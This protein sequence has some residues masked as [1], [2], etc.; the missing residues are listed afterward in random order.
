MG[1]GIILGLLPVA[2]LALLGRAGFYFGNAVYPVLN[3]VYRGLLFH[4]FGNALIGK[5]VY[6]REELLPNP[7]VAS[8]LFGSVGMSLIAAVRSLRTGRRLPIGIP[9][10]V[11]F[12]LLLA[13]GSLAPTPLWYQYFY[14]PV[15][16][17]ILALVLSASALA[18]VEWRQAVPGAVFGLVVV[19]SAAAGWSRMAILSRLADP[20]SWIPVEVHHAGKVLAGRVKEG[21]VLTL[22]PIVPLEGGLQ[23]FPEFA[24]GP[25]TWRVA[26]LLSPE[27]RDR[28]GVVSYQ[29]FS[30]YLESDPPSAIA[31]GF[32]AKNE[33]FVRG[34]EGGVEDPLR[35][36][37][38]ENGYTPI[39][40][41][42]D[43]TPEP[44]ILWVRD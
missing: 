37:A 36:Y 8:L 19:V 20:S 27:R 10:A 41:D 9:L 17:L 4:W 42:A 6:L 29:D 7:A 5:M 39:S 32:E 28:Y 3:S 30:A 15:P 11:G 33:G 22:G 24:A 40:L 18:D 38:R 14:A 16:F 13:V 1:F 26:H 2:A 44:I 34:E 31:V 43:F 35:T 23:I 12:W 25:F 21:R